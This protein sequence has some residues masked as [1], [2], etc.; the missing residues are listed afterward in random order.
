MSKFI[1]PI[2]FIVFFL[3][4][5]LFLG[6]FFITYLT[7]KSLP[8][9]NRIVANAL[10]KKDIKIFRNNYAIPNIVGKTNED[11]FFALGYV[12][13][14]DRLWQM[15]LLRKTAKGKLAEIFGEKYLEN[16][17]LMR[18]LD[19]YNNSKNSV[20][21]LSERTLT[22]LE[23][24]S[25]GINKRLIDIQN[26]GLGRGSP[27]LFLF[28]PK[29]SP[30][31]PADSL[32][33]LKLYD[34]SNNESAKNEIIRLNLLNFGLP[35]NRLLD[36]YPDIPNISNSKLSFDKNIFSEINY[37]DDNTHL[38][39]KLNF[40]KNIFSQNSNIN[41]ASNIWAAL[42]SRTASG[43]T[44]VGFNL[45][46]NF[47]IPI[48]WMLTRLELDTGP[49]IG[50][51]IPGIPAVITGRSKYFS[52][53]F[54]SSKLDNQDLIIEI[55][56]EKNKNEYKSSN[57]FKKFKVRNILI[58]VKGKPG[59]THRILSSENGPIIP[60]NAYGIKS[61]QSDKVVFA[62]KWTGLSN[63]DR[64]IETFINIMLS[65]NIPDA[66]RYLRHLVVP[67]VNIL[68]ANEDKVEIISAGKIPIR[69]KRNP[70]NYGIIPS[71]GGSKK[72][73]WLGHFNHDQN[74]NIKIL[75]NGVIFNTN[76]KLLN[77][78]FPIH[79][80]YDW[81][82][83]QRSFRM[84]N[85]FEKRKYHTLESF[86]EIQIDNISPSARILLPLLAK[87]L[88]YSQVLDINNKY[89][90]LRKDSLDLL[91]EWNGEMSM[92]LAQP[93]IFYSWAAQFQ[94]MV[95]QDEIGKN[96]NWFKSINSDFL[97]RV[98]R[99]INGA[100]QWCDIKQTDKIETC[101]DISLNAL[102]NALVEISNK[103]GN[104]IEKWHWGNFHK[105]HFID[106]VIGKYPLLSYLTNLV[107]EVPGGDNT[108]SMN[109]TNNSLENQFHVNYGSTLRIIIDFSDEN[110]SYFSI[111]TGQSGH[112]LSRNY[113]DFIELWQRN[114]YVKIPLL[115]DNIIDERNH[116]ML[117]T[118]SSN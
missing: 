61:I 51:T 54:A 85:L 101:E 82:N 102:D 78:E 26:E 90:N 18:T 11:T 107:F 46:T 45:H 73:Y 41:N 10:V 62:L 23:S 2:K 105:A 6:I 110:N 77:K 22:L 20:R 34:L 40:T 109:R 99:N 103:Y 39:N 15:I 87:D 32:A 58:K 50:A 97:E 98:L 71:L 100:S 36:L 67:S 16:D 56:N 27:I 115:Q 28:P 63:R 60:S 42:G 112:F 57:G 114:K 37:R 75:N 19:I 66:K 43:N 59:I 117:I 94:K 88:W 13:A 49:I 64:S 72:Q 113:D 92:Y 80:S 55:L 69:N 38:N 24:Y 70:L 81:G 25:N 29:I 53:G 33:I 96:I 35:Y 95:I 86:E 89:L 4:T 74:A 91:A 21:F 47:Q 17:K 118:K 1:K 68:L 31:T 84:Q 108:L 8:D 93:L 48:M 44:L 104:D 79:H 5:V 76:N 65:N 106:D 111:P 7:I 14:Q 30:W 12:H 9:Y 83:K 116:L 3:F 52:W